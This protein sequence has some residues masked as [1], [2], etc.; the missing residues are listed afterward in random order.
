MTDRLDDL[1]L[2]AEKGMGWRPS[3]SRLRV[4]QYFVS[5]AEDLWHVADSV[6]IVVWRPFDRIEHA[7]MLMCALGIR[8]APWKDASGQ[9]IGWAAAP[10][11]DRDPPTS[12]D[13]NTPAVIAHAVTECALRIVRARAQA[14]AEETS[15]HA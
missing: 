4:G 13:G 10:P 3:T 2:L 6:E 12:V 15:V 5:A 7:A 8:L 14:R 11:D 9:I 1:I